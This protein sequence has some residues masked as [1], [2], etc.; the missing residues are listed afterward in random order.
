MGSG[1]GIKKKESLGCE[2]CI[3]G[4]CAYVRE[5]KEGIF[6]VVERRSVQRDERETRRR[7]G[8]REQKGGER[9]RGRSVRK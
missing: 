4:E 6:M 8:G 3:G 2:M 9:E 5:I 1:E 7:V